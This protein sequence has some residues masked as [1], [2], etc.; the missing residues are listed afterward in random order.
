MNLSQKRII[1]I[2]IL[3]LWNDDRILELKR[4]RYLTRKEIVEILTKGPVEFVIANIGDK[5]TWIPTSK[6]FE[7]WKSDIKEHVVENPE[8][9]EL[10]DYPEDYAYIAS[11][12]EGLQD[13]PIILLETCH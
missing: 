8:H 6:C 12:W 11:E 3:E 13:R 2:P 10:E 5:L 1:Q 7:I 9:I 4:N